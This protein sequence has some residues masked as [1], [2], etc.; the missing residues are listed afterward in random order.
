M[1]GTRV[2][3]LTL[4]AFPGVRVTELA[5]ADGYRFG[6]PRRGQVDIFKKGST[7]PHAT[8]KCLCGSSGSGC[9]LIVEGGLALC[10]A[11]TCKTCGFVTKVPDQNF[12]DLLGAVFEEPPKKRLF[13]LPVAPGVRL[14]KFEL[15]EGHDFGRPRGGN[16]HVI[17]RRNGDTTTTL[18]CICVGGAGGCT[19][20]VTT[21]VATCKSSG[22]TN[23]TFGVV[24]KA[25]A[26]AAYMEKIFTA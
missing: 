18:Q 22:C 10:S 8:V 4:P 1:P 9:Q 19:L 17:E 5:V 7:A 23:C 24:V 16:V 2:K 26:F 21:H 15:A 11:G 25:S 14:T 6:E 13:P 12:V 3:M 20:D